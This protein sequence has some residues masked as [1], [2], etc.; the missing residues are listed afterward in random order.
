LAAP[1]L[2]SPADRASNVS[3]TPTFT[4]NASTG[5]TT[6]KVQVST[7][8]S[9][10]ALVVN[11]SGV[12]ATSLAITSALAS[13][14]TLYWRVQAVNGSTTSAWSTSRRFTTAR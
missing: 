3:R 8:S 1:V 2:V 11:Q 9:F 10:T 12:S 5:A 4:W 6:Y 13:R 14:R 7:N